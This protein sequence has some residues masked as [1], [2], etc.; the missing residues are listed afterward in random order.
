MLCYNAIDGLDHTLL[1][2]EDTFTTLQQED[3]KA[4]TMS[5]ASWTSL[6][7]VQLADTKKVTFAPPE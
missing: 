7:A 1:K 3:S 4:I 6:P 2:L 5:I